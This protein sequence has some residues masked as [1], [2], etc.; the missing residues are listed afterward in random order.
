MSPTDSSD[1]DVQTQSTP[2]VSPSPPNPRHMAF[3]Q[4]RFQQQQQL[5]L[6]QKHQAGEYATS[7]QPG[8]SRNSSPLSTPAA[9]M[10]G[11]R[12]PSKGWAEHDDMERSQSLLSKCTTGFGF[13]VLGLGLRV[14]SSGTEAF[15]RNAPLC[16]RLDEVREP[17]A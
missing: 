12:S 14:Q 1:D 10:R 7:P 15:C 2:S 5:Y 6:N 9:A 4:E 17:C 3:A 13:R 16:A 11:V 8:S